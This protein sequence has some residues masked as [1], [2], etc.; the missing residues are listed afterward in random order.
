MTNSYTIRYVFE[1][2]A[3]MERENARSKAS[4]LLR[5]IE[6]MEF[7]HR[8][9][10]VIWKTAV[11]AKAFAMLAEDRAMI[12]NATEIIARTRPPKSAAERRA[13]HDKALRV[14]A[15]LKRLGR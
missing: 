1:R 12:M 9:R 8:P 11:K 13:I 4:A 5:E 3:E 2:S 6:V 10:A 14:L 7:C 15:R